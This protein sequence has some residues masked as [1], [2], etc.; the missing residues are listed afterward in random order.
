MGAG[1]MGNGMRAD[2]RERHM[3]PVPEEYAN[4]T[5]P[6]AAD[7]ESIARGQEHFNLFCASCH[8]ETGL[9]DG[10]AAA[11]LDPAPP[12]IAQTSLMLNDDFL[13]WRIS[14][15]GS[16]EPFNS[17]MPAW[18]ATLDEQARWDVI[19]YVRSLGGV[20]GMGSGGRGNE[21]MR[22][23]MQATM[24]DELIAAGIAQGVIDEADG[25]IFREIHARV[26]AYRDAVGASTAGDAAVAE[27]DLLM[28]MV[29]DGQ[30]SQSDADAFAGI[31]ARL[32][33]AGLM[34]Q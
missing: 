17:A 30:L 25:E 10:P 15:G 22:A 32:E 33:A 11:G 34:P 7:A 31:H 23:Q 1:A 18:K 12:M 26:E 20:D 4:L 16:L 5:S 6:I 3:V 29:E 13:F 21:A 28:A 24:Q 14:E 27:G 19:N 2:L 9:G 8:G